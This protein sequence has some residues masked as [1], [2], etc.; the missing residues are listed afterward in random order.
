MRNRI[1]NGAMQISQE[2]GDT[3]GTAG[4]YY[5]ADQWVTGFTTSA[6]IITSIRNQGTTPNGSK[7][8]YRVTITVADAALAAGEFLYIGHKIEGNRIADFRY[9]SAAAKQ[10]ILRFGFKGPT[11]TYSIQLRN[12]AGDRSYVALFT[13]AAGQANADTEQIFVI[14]G[15]VIGTWL[16]DTEIGIEFRCVLA[17]GTTFHGVTGWQA[18]NILGTSA[19]SNGMA[20]AGAVFELFDVGLYLDPDSTG[21]PPPWQMPDEVQELTACQRYWQKV[22]TEF[23]GSVTSG[24]N[25]Y[26]RMPVVPTMRINPTANGTNVTA[27]TGFAATVGTPAAISYTFG[28]VR[29]ANATAASSRYVTDWELSARL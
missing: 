23:S 8:R 16:T 3:A 4:G 6:G 2:N 19:I 21:K 13:I 29:A 22:R 11:G 27:A 20:T 14:P 5:A 28:E 24:S 17:A 25:F 26:S 12:G 10:A 1:I 15:D 18:G 7:Y 9:G